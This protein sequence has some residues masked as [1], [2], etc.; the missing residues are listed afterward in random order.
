MSKVSVPFPTVA[1][2]HIVD[3]QKDVEKGNLQP[4]LTLDHLLHSNHQTVEKVED[5]DQDRHDDEEE[6]REGE[7]ED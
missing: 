3:I 2:K 5:R 7:L 4:T 1:I 6:D